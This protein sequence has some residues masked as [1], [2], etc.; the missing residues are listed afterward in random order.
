M[1]IHELN[2][3]SG[4][5]GAGNFFATDN[6]YDTSKIS[7]EQLMAIINAR[8]DNIIAGG[9]APSAAEITDARQGAAVLGG[10]VYASLGAA[11]RTQ[12]TEVVNNGLHGTGQNITS[13]TG[14]SICNDDLNNLTPN[15]IYGLVPY[16]GLAHLPV[17]KYGSNNGG[18]I[19]TISKQLAANATMTQVF[20]NRDGDIF[21]RQYWGNGYESWFRH[22]PTD[23][24]FGG[25]K[26]NITSSNVAAICNG[27]ANNLPNNKAYGISIAYT[28]MA[29][30]PIY[31]DGV[32]SKYAG[33]VLTYGKETARGYGDVQIFSGY[34]SQTYIR[35]YVGT[36]QNWRCLSDH[37]F[38]DILGVGDSICEGWRNGNRGFVGLLDVPY[39]NLGI[40]GATLGRAE[41][42]TQIY[43]EIESISY[44]RDVIIADGGINDYYQDVP[45]GTLPTIPAVNDTE[46]AAIDKTTVSGGLSYLLYLMIKKMPR[47]QR[48]F[49]I[50]HKTNRCPYRQNGAGYTQQDLHDRIVE[51]CKLY[52]V[53]VIDIYE[54]SV[55]NSAYSQY[56]SPTPYA[57]DPSVTTNYYVDNDGV[58]PLMLGYQ[59]GYM[60]L[61]KAA[62]QTATTKI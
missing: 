50:T 41:G 22:S 9:A 14:P 35:V 12:I 32:N 62:L 58:H 28:A 16:Q 47:A 48:Y 37:K 5:L 6:G 34:G 53:I 49:L 13:S 55:I 2:T 38:N 10:A 36:W 15:T 27:D 20:I 26:E 33:A 40:T 11:I 30:M 43:T 57:D 17:E 1:E 7:Y 19:Y 39:T 25:T 45:L 59:E 51:I 29:N 3:F 61:V 31:P 46:A 24:L 52:N 4:T 18:I 54:K 42:H 56:L 21:T 23:L 60:P 44:T 8:I